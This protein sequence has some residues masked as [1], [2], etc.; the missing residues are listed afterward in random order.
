MPDR[1]FNDE[2]DY[3]QSVRALDGF[4]QLDLAR[5]VLHSVMT[6][7]DICRKGALLPA[8]A[9]KQLGSSLEYSFTIAAPGLALAHFLRSA[10]DEPVTRGVA[11]PS[12]RAF[13]IDLVQAERPMAYVH[14]LREQL[15]DVLPPLHS[16]RS[17]TW[18]ESETLVVRAKRPP[19][20]PTLEFQTNFNAVGEQDF[21]PDHH[22]TLRPQL[23]KA[24]I[25]T[26]D[27]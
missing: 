3:W 27:L 4:L 17:F 7:V 24:Y 13:G 11:A 5:M 14:A 16:D 26:H 22:I 9:Q 20:T 6:P 15:E 2:V 25:Q 23:K 18:Y 12:A 8:V 10:F 21:E 19:A 1:Q